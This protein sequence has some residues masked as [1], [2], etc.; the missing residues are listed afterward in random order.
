MQSFCS[1]PDDVFE[2]KNFEFIEKIY[3]YDDLTTSLLKKLYGASSEKNPDTFF[4]AEIYYGLLENL[5]LQQVNLGVEIKKIRAVKY[6]TQVELYKRLNYAKDFIQACYMNEITIDTLASVACLNAAYFLRE[7]KKYF[8]VTPHQYIITQRLT[9]AKKMLQSTSKNIKEICF[10]V[11]YEDVSS[12]S[13]LFKKNFGI[14][15]AA[16]QSKK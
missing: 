11:G 2:N 9:A 3:K 10:A 14:T 8:G 5:I 4:I 12:F 1:D 7:F 15:P 13:K 6:S 16:C